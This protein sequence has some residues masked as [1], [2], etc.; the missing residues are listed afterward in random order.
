MISTY[1]TDFNA[2]LR[3]CKVWCDAPRR[4]CFQT[5][6]IPRSD[7]RRGV[8][9][10]LSWSTF[11][12]CSKSLKIGTLKTCPTEF[13]HKLGASCH[14]FST[15]CSISFRTHALGVGTSVAIKNRTAVTRDQSTQ[16]RRPSHRDPPKIS[17]FVSSFETCLAGSRSCGNCR[18]R[19][20][21]RNLIRG[22]RPFFIAERRVISEGLCGLQRQRPVLM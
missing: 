19:E 8:P 5:I 10:I 3:E 7:S 21:G 4:K 9:V 13:I 12:T 17:W 11:S 15:G 6:A 16:P 14:T 1:L 2:R 18:N 20:R 22:H